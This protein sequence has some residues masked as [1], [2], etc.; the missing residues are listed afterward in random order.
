MK[1]WYPLRASAVLQDR[2]L[3]LVERRALDELVVAR[4]AQAP[5]LIVPVRDERVR[6]VCGVE[7][8]LQHH[9]FYWGLRLTGLVRWRDDAFTDARA[10]RTA[11][12]R[13][14]R[15]FAA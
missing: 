4:Q 10:C 14:A 7:P 3:V 2:R 9:G 5:Q 1:V 13:P 8:V 15:L 11:L 6:V 12:Q